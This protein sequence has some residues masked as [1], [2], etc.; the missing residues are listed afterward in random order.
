MTDNAR[1]D[2]FTS[3]A[4]SD[5]NPF[6]AWPSDA[7]AD[8]VY[9][10][11]NGTNASAHAIIFTPDAGFNVKL[12]GLSL[13][14]WA[15]GPAGLAGY[16][17]DWTVS[18]SVSGLIDSGTFQTVDG[19]DTPFTFGSSGSI[20]GANGEIITLR[21]QQLNGTGSY[22]AMDNLSFD[23][24]VVP[25]PSAALLGAAGLGAMAMRRRRK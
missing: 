21:L 10:L 11:D 24:V 7:M 25:E 23:Q 18:G 15:Q 14:D 22:L 16:N 9:Q 19:T 4:T 2:A 13:N 5:Y 3:R 17:V 12:Q 1:W 8:G 6:T 20:T